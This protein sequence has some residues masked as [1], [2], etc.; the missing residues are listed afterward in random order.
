VN[1]GVNS[2]FNYLVPRHSSLRLVTAGGFGAVQAGSVR[3][4]PDAGN[5]VPTAIS[6]FSFKNAAQTTVTESSVPAQPPGSTFRLYLETF[7]TSG[8]PGGVDSGVAVANPSDNP[9]T[10]TFSLMDS[11]GSPLNITRSINIPARGQVANFTNEIFQGQLPSSFQGI[12]NVTVSSQFSSLPTIALTALHE[13]WNE[14]RD[15][16]ITTTPPMDQDAPPA[17]LV[18]FPQVVIGGGYTTDFILF[19]QS[20]MG[21]LWLYN[22]DGF[23]RPGTALTIPKK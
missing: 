15:F 23:V 5:N 9:V 8:M 6:I 21:N 14:N 18:L 19:G 17:T 3:V 12:A 20:G 2:T 10:V 22:Q 4:V 11:N 13:R 1:G 16:L 7:G